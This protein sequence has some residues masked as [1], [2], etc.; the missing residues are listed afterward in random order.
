MDRLPV[1][2]SNVK[3]VGYDPETQALEIEFIVA[4]GKPPSIY[5][6]RELAPS[7]AMAQIYA[8]MCKTDVS[9]GSIFHQRVKSNPD[10]IVSKLEDDVAA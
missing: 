4:D 7:G 1:A 10:M 5:R 2:S 3:S 8:D 6:C 9:V